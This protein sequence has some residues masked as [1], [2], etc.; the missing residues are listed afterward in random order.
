VSSNEG[1]IKTSPTALEQFERCRLQY[2]IERIEKRRPQYDN[3]PMLL[4]RA[5]HDTLNALLREHIKVGKERHLDMA[6]A[7]VLFEEFWEKHRCSEQELFVDG[8]QM[9]SNL[10]EQQEMVDPEKVFALEHA[11]EFT[12]G[13]EVLVRGRIDRIDR[14]E[15][16]DEETGEI[17]LTLYIYDYKTTR[18]WLTTRDVADSIQIACYSIAAKIIEPTATRLRSGLWLL[19]TGEPILIS[20]TDTELVDWTDYIVTTARQ[21]QTEK[22]WA[23]S[24]NVNCVYCSCSDECEEY[25]RALRGEKLFFAKDMHDYDTMAREREDINDILRILE[26]R[27]KE[28]TAAI[29][30]FLAS[31]GEGAEMG[32]VYYRLSRRPRDSFPIGE[33]V[34]IIAERTGEPE[35]TVMKAVGTVQTKAVEAFLKEHARRTNVGEAGMIRAALANISERSYSTT[36]YHRKSG[37]KNK[38]DKA[39]RPSSGRKTEGHDERD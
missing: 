18:Q 15:S 36:L 39:Q 32:D 16:M 3:P 2:F 21:I 25:K 33:T 23:P 12:L 24:L 7:H 27:K 4:G 20:H 29:K 1:L 10:C 28:L 35:D 11:F 38:A 14:E 8:L 9:I 13:D 22:T 19:R 5:A 30:E 26:A 31:S 17:F 37:G 34:R 6:L